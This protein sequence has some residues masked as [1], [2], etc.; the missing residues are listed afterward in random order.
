MMGKKLRKASGRFLLRISPELHEL[1]R[2]S[3]REMG[4]S[5][6]EYCAMKLAAPVANLAPVQEAVDAVGRAAGLFGEELVAVAV[7]G[8]WA[9]GEAGPDSDVD[10]LIVLDGGI[11]LSRDLYRKW[12]E[13]LIR[14]EGM[15]VEPHF[16]RLPSDSRRVS[17]LWAEVALEGIV[18]FE[19]ELRL[20]RWLVRVRRAIVQGRV[21]RRVVN[22]QP[23]WSEGE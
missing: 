4:V 14:W 10:L 16:V 20:S 17:G 2:S 22:G 21:V 18:L 5:L 13:D 3:A 19:R 12:D 7:F 23:Y 1:L 6:N 8:S 9:R 11:S 15:N